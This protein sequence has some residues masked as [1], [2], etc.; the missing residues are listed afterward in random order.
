[1]RVTLL[2]VAAVTVASNDFDLRLTPEPCLD[3]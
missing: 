3:S 1:M 2:P